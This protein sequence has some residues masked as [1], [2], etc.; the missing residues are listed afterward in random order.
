MIGLFHCPTPSSRELN[1]AL[2]DSV[3]GG[4]T[5]VLIQSVAV[6]E[7]NGDMDEKTSQTL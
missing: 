6:S 1:G 2:E 4:P 3:V 5:R 7:N